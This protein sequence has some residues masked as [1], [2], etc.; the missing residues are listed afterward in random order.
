LPAYGRGAEI[1]P[2]SQ[3][4]AIH[5]S[6]SFPNG[7]VPYAAVIAIE[8]SDMNVVHQRVEA[9]VKHNNNNNR[10]NDDDDKKVNNKNMTIG[11]GATTTGANTPRTAVRQNLSLLLSKKQR[12]RYL[13][14]ILRRAAAKE[15]LDAEQY[16]QQNESSLYKLPMLIAFSLIGRGWIRPMDIAVVAC[17]STYFIVLNMV[18]QSSRDWTGTP[19]LPATPPQG[20]VPTIVSHPLGRRMDTSKLYNAWLRGGVLVGLVSPTIL[21]LFRSMVDVKMGTAITMTTAGVDVTGIPVGTIR[22]YARPLFL[23]CCQMVTEAFFRRNL[24]RS[25]RS[26][27]KCTYQ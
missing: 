24:V 10:V 17:W 6:D 11:V 3:E 13:H 2:E 1:W 18:A 26:V 12:Q 25:D 15:E 4:D 23:L 7:Q 22:V 14:R 27:G 8:Q 21:L 19:I 16:Q 5:L 20:H 9:S